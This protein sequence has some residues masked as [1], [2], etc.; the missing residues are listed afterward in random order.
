V[1]VPADVPVQVDHAGVHHALGALARR[2]DQLHHVVEG[3]R[4]GGRLP[5]R[6]ILYLRVHC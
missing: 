4:V 6:Q 2:T 1:Q 3:P 5:A